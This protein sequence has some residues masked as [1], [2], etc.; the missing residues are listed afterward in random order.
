MGLLVVTGFAYILFQSLK[1]EYACKHGNTA[2]CVQLEPSGN[3]STV[4]R[5]P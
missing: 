4:P 2:V 5:L 3:H 1:D